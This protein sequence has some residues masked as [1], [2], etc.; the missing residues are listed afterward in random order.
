M[1]NILKILGLLLLVAMVVTACKKSDVVKSQED[2]DYNTIEPIIYAISGPAITAAS[3]LAPVTYTA[4]PRG[5][6]SYSWEVIGHGA[7]I[8]VLDPSFEAEITFDQSDVD[9]TVQVK[10]IETS[11]SGKV[12]DP[13]IMS[14]DLTKFKPMTF[15]E[16]L[17]TWTGVET[18]EGGNTYDITVELTAGPDEN[19]LIF[20]VDGDGIPS[21]MSGLFLGWGEAF[22]TSIE[23]QGNII[24]TINLQS[25]AVDIFCQYIGQTLPGPWDYNFSGEGTWEGFNKSMTIN[26]ALQWDDNCDANYNPSTITLTKQ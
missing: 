16:F 7:S 9:K 23:P 6:S 5:G 21:L 20:P 1:K 14:V 22:Q 19:T 25:G 26:F 24:A 13:Y 18:D 2:Y 15:D 8:N 4:T 12:S 10:C 17:G 11:A 3:G